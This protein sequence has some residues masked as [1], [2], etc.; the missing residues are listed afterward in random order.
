M[1]DE[2]DNSGDLGGLGAMRILAMGQPLPG[3]KQLDD[4]ANTPVMDPSTKWLRYAQGALRGGNFAENMGNA[5]GGYADATDK[6][7][8][9]RAKYL[10]I[11][12]QA[13]LQ[14]QGMMLNQ[15]NTQ[16]KLQGEWDDALSGGLTGLMSQ[17]NRIDPQSVVQMAVGTAQQKG[18]PPVYVQQWLGSLPSTP[19]GLAAYARAKSVSGMGKDTRLGAV[20]P[21]VELPNTGGGLTPMN[22]NPNAPGGVGPQPGGVPM[23]LKPEDALLETVDTPRGKFVFSKVTGKAALAG[24]PEAQALAA[25]AQAAVRSNP[26]AMLPGGAPPQIAV[27]GV[28]PDASRPA[29]A[30]PLPGAAPSTSL[31]VDPGA[32]EAEKKYGGEFGAYQAGLDD[33]IGALADLSTRV[34]QMTKYQQDF[35]SGA[36][37]EMRGKGAAWA[38]DI[39]LS[40]GVPQAQADTVANG[41]AG[42]KIDSMQAFQKLSV[43]G[44][45]EA[46]K[47]A[48]QNSSGGNAGRMTQAEFGIF[49]KNNPSL[50]TDPRAIE[51]I[52][53]F[54]AEQYRKG[55]AE[56][57]FVSRE[58]KRG[59]PIQEI[60]S[61]WAQMQ[62]ASS[63]APTVTQGVIKGTTK[64]PGGAQTSKLGTSLSGKK[65][66]QNAEGDWEY[67][68]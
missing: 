13:L 49:A 6:E 62:G 52:Y 24:S 40:F 68:E 66:R 7:S 32:L 41:M 64:P 44:A 10:P 19:D 59:A 43:Q 25:E 50:E 31:G 21:K 58:L 12:A 42:G 33:K 18:I 46:L 26:G 3:A 5:L 23:S 20:S 39:L 38:K 51:K 15:A 55:L 37:A 34:G 36:T 11:V 30:P 63:N 65:I 8:E 48:M 35:R 60:R 1:A 45:M 16:F 54:L 2:Q 28:V 9:L 14:R 47:S 29:G 56:Q 17:G 4:L 22:T 67:V 27:P 57:A 61:T 53:A